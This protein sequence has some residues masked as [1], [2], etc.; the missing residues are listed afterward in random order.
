M[1]GQA[2][3]RLCVKSVWYYQ[4]KHARNQVQD[5]TRSKGDWGEGKQEKTVLQ[6]SQ[7]GTEHSVIRA[8]LFLVIDWFNKTITHSLATRAKRNILCSIFSHRDAETLL[9]TGSFSLFQQVTQKDLHPLRNISSFNLELWVVTQ[10][11]GPAAHLW[12]RVQIIL[13]S[14]VNQSQIPNW[15]LHFSSFIFPDLFC[16]TVYVTQTSSFATWGFSRALLICLFVQMR[17]QTVK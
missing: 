2:G 5:S 11:Q 7:E 8:G 10:C 16:L 17:H 9:D 4:N 6:P 15:L 12:V 14:C 1:T 3:S 13:F